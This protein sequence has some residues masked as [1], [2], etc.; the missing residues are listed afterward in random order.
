MEYDLNRLKQ[1]TVANIDYMPVA[2][3]A[4]RH[5]GLE[6]SYRLIQGLFSYVNSLIPCLS[7]ADRKKQVA[8][9]PLL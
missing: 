5:R 1:S 3:K 4:F 2:T 6:H 9:T 7:I 8:G